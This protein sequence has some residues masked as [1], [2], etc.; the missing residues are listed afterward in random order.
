MSFSSQ[1][2]VEWVTP[3]GMKDG[4]RYKVVYCDFVKRCYAVEG[5]LRLPMSD[6]SECRPP[7]EDVSA[8]LEIKDGYVVCGKDHIAKLCCNGKYKVSFN[9][10]KVERFL[11]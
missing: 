10:F 3:N 6:Y 11:E 7:L 5:G 2:L 1:L 4:Y 9:P 8:E